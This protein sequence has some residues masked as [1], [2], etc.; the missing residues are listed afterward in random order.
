MLDSYSQ[1][2]PCK[3]KHTTKVTE[4]F[5]TSSTNFHKILANMNWWL[6]HIGFGD[7]LVGWLVVRTYTLCKFLMML[8]LVTIW[9]LFYDSK[10]YKVVLLISQYDISYYYNFH[11]NLLTKNEIKSNFQLQKDTMDIILQDAPWV[12]CTFICLR[13]Q[14]SSVEVIIQQR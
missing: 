11:E 6:S 8:F 13:S 7:W 10:W 5:G 1:K 3:K 9:L 12:W 14:C 2:T 4:L